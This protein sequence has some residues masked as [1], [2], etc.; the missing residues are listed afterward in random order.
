MERVS[1]INIISFSL[2]LSFFYILFSVSTTA[3]LV[4]DQVRYEL[5][6]EKKDKGIILMQDNKMMFNDLSNNISSIFDLDKDQMTIIDHNKKTYTVATP[7]DFVRAAEKVTKNLKIEMDKHLKNIPPDQRKKL[8]ELIDKNQESFP[9]QN[10]NP[11]TLTV[12]STGETEEIAGFN[13]SKY[14]VFRNAQ[15]SEELWVSKEIGYHKEIDIT[16]MARLMREFKKISHQFGGQV[17]NDDAYIEIFE[18]GGF[19]LKTINY[20]FGNNVYVEEVENISTREI[21]ESELKTPKGYKERSLDEV[22]KREF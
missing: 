20:S 11:V 1:R 6:G 12:S 2:Y 7:D 19:P 9:A 16:K 17:I 4:M 22:F 18:N 13:S 15:L 14:K 5:E 3:G 8:K 21:E 10:P